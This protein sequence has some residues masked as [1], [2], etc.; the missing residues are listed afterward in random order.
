MFNSCGRQEDQ[1]SFPDQ[2]PLQHLAG[3]MLA[4]PWPKAEHDD[5]DNFSKTMQC[6]V[7]SHWRE[8]THVELRYTVARTHML[9]YTIR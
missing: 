2:T 8:D 1:D 3:A 4:L 6:T 5:G 7:E 9:I